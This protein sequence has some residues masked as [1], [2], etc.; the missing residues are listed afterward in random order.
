MGEP[1]GLPSMGSHR[2]G[3]DWSDLAAAAAAAAIS[4]LKEHEGSSCEK[5]T[6]KIL[7][8]GAKGQVP[9]HS[10]RSPQWREVCV[11]VCAEGE[12]V[13]VGGGVRGWLFLTESE[14]SLEELGP[15]EMRALERKWPWDITGVEEYEPS[16]YSLLGPLGP[17]KSIFLSLA[18]HFMIRFYALAP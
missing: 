15:A 9:T 11:C 13:C 1:G 18:M 16:S 7:V 3:H 2:V 17:V 4:T 8:Y 5:I 10:S 12:C 6:I 14:P